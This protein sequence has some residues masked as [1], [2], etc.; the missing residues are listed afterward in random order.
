MIYLVKMFIICSEFSAESM[1]GYD[2]SLIY[3]NW[4]QV[5]QLAIDTILWRKI[6][7]K[8]NDQ[9]NKKWN[10]IVVVI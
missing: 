9:S 4:I 2:T 8:E 10:N 6:W 3:L 7:N 1:Q 5:Y